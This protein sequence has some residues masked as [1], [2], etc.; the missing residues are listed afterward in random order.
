MAKHKQQ[1]QQDE[2][3]LR[4]NEAIH[5]TKE[6]AEEEELEPISVNSAWDEEESFANAQAPVA[7]EPLEEETGAIAEEEQ[8]TAL[9]EE[10]ET[11]DY[12]ML[13]A[14]ERTRIGG[15]LHEKPDERSTF[16][17]RAMP[18]PRRAR[19][20]KK[21]KNPIDPK[22]M[23]LPEENFLLDRKVTPLDLKAHMKLQQRDFVGS[24]VRKPRDLATMFD[25]GKSTKM[26]PKLDLGYAISENYDL[27]RE[28][29]AKQLLRNLHSRDMVER[30]NATKV[31]KEMEIDKE[32]LE[33][34]Q[35]D[36]KAYLNEEFIEKLDD[37]IPNV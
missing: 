7:Q 11:A 23:G 2:E 26:H 22:L 35:N 20:P 34:L 27:R 30:R 32:F 8:Q 1:K 5:A 18:L 12:S 36:K 3:Q 9:E 10:Q 14:A 17:G 28:M 24:N 21:D 25:K 15:K 33:E 4:S 19:D 13:S 37:K 16:R 29:I 31:L 6:Y